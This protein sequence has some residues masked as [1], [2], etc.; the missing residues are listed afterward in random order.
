[1]LEKFDGK[2]F[3]QALRHTLL[4]GLNFPSDKIFF[5]YKPKFIEADTYITYQ[6]LNELR[7]DYVADKPT[8]ITWKIQVNIY[9]NSDYDNLKDKI[10]ETLEKNGMI[11][12]DTQELYLDELE[13]YHVPIRFK[14]KTMLKK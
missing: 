6:I 2:N 11:C 5:A 3:K 4:E 8:S 14:Y 1:M 10:I 13:M 9:S 7:E 12:Y